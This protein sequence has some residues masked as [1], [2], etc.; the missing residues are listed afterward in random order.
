MFRQ[1]FHDG[2]VAWIRCHAQSCK[3]MSAGSISQTLMLMLVFSPERPVTWLVWII[4]TADD[5]L[6]MFPI[7]H[8]QGWEYLQHSNRHQQYSYPGGHRTGEVSNLVSASWNVIPVRCYLHYLHF[9]CRYHHFHFHF[10]CRC[11]Y[12]CHRLDHVSILWRL[13]GTNR[14]IG[15]MVEMVHRAPERNTLSQRMLSIRRTPAWL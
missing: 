7:G 4:C 14:S 13:Q 15:G 11:H 3:W 5:D 6:H 1:T 10:H 8:I 2:S 12:H 9:R